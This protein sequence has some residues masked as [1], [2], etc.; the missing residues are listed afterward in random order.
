[1]SAAKAACDHMHD[2]WHGTAAGK[3]VSMGVMSDGS[4]GIP[5]DI[6]FSFPVNIV[7]KQWQ[8]VQG[9]DIDD[10]SREKFNV[11]ANELLEERDEAINVCK[12]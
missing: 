8:I 5:K 6:V 3:W 4:Y 12:L 7:N 1:M 11:T 9:L 10:F 2:W